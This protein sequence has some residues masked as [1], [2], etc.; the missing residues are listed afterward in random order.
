MAFRM[1]ED[2][3]ALGNLAA[4][5]PLG[6]ATIA[7]LSS[8]ERQVHAVLAQDGWIE[9]HDLAEVGEEPSWRFL[10]DVL[11]D[12]ILLS[13]LGSRR[14]TLDLRL[15]EIVQAGEKVGAVP[16]LPIPHLYDRPS[17]SIWYSQWFT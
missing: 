4:L 12:R 1:P 6:E 8:P 5:L 7:Q 10:H 14:A 3:T 16:K 11:A 17:W 2:D 13:H 15:A 9:R